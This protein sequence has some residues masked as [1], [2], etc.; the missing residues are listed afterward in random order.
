MLGD[1]FNCITFGATFCLLS[2]SL[3][4]TKIGSDTHHIIVQM[5]NE[6]VA[7]DRK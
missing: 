3:G 7:P 2:H 5:I 1:T 6:T 4:R